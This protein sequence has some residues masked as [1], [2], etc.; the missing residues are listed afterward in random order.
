[1]LLNIFR[2]IINIFFKKK[3]KDINE[4]LFNKLYKELEEESGKIIF[5]YIA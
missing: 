5:K 4:D 2:R 3:A 1:M